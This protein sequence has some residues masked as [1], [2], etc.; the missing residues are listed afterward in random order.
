MIGG[1]IFGAAYVI[2]FFVRGLYLPGLVGGVLGGV[3]LYLILKEADARKQRRWEE[4]AG[5][6]S[7][8]PDDPTFN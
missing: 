5:S 8:H 3:L 2:A 4:K 7:A 1:V 6:P